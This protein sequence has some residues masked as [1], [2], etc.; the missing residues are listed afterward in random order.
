[1][2]RSTPP[3]LFPAVCCIAR[4][5]P[6]G[7]PALSAFTPVNVFGATWALLAEVDEAEAYAGLKN[8]EFVLGTVALDQARAEGV[9]KDGSLVL[10]VAFG[11]G[12]VW[13]PALMRM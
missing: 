8:L 4:T 1:M 10:L 9:V 13:G 6:N 2:P 5:S 7:N 3:N 12:S 11:S